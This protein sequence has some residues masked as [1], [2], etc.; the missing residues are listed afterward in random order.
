M[1]YASTDR[2][3]NRR[4]DEILKLMSSRHI[5]LIRFFDFFF[6]RY[7]FLYLLYK[8]TNFGDV[9]PETISDGDEDDDVWYAVTRVR[10]S[11]VLVL[12]KTKTDG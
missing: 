7:Y 12:Q 9:R 5:V 1:V 11:F 10:G 6:S 3:L 4:D 8:Y 2:I